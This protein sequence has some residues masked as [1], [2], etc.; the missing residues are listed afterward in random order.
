MTNKNTR[1]AFLASL[2][3]LLL[4]VSSLLGTTYAWFTDSVTSSNNIISSGNLDVEL[5]YQVEGQSDWT[6]VTDTTNIFKENALWEPGHTEVVKLKVVNEGTLALKYN[7]GVNVASE[8]GSVNAAGNPFKLSDFIK[9]GIVE[10]AQD[11]TRDEAIAAVDAFATALNTAYNSGST[12]LDAKNDTDSDEKIVTMVV[13][14]PTTVD[15]DANAMK[16]AIIPTINLGLNLFAT[17]LVQEE[18]SFG[19]NFDENA[20]V[21]YLYD[22]AKSAKENAAALQN[23]IDTTA[24]GAIIVVSAGTYD[25]S[26][27]SGNQIKLDKDNVTLLGQSGV[28]IN[29]DGETGSSNTQAVIKITG[30]NVT[31]S[32]IYA[33]DKGEN[34]VILAFGNNVTITNCTLKGYA[35][36]A[37]GQYLEAGVMIV[38]NDVVNHP[39]TKYTVT[40][41]TFI[42]CNISLQNGVGNG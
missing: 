6:K 4:C 31:V 24:E 20:Y 10:G 32:Y 35:S 28:I 33:V 39:I 22:N 5:Y 40:S 2:M 21:E 11:Y 29:D 26:G 9:Y 30:D 19:N 18:D 42:D 25:V 8:I 36:S 13:Y 41:N 12:A 38:A 23:L 1:R 27:I 15:N 16:G 7:L 3:A 17:Q 34:T 14:M 37:W